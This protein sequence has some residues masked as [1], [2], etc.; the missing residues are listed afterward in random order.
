TAAVI[1]HV[2]AKIKLIDTKEDSFE[3]DYESLG[4]VISSKTK[5]IIAVDI[6][7]K[8]CDYDKIFEQIN[9]KRDCFKANNKFQSLFNRIVLISD[10][11]HG[12]G[13]KMYDLKSGNFA[14]FTCFSF[15]A[16]KNLTTAE[17]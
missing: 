16:V 4:E 15:H 2:G 11:A 5:A 12:F 1:H 8:L 9:K 10:S 14:D 7:G 6:G 13:A 17:G 3:M